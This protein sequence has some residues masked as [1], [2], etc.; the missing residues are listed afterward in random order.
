MSATAIVMMIVALLVLWGG[1]AL[2][3][4]HLHKHPDEE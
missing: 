1:L 2:S 4:I 3:L